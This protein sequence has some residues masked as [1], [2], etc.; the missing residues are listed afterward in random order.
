MSP[1]ENG[2][3]APEEIISNQIFLIRG[4]KVMLDKDLAQLYNIETDLQIGSYGGRGE[5]EG[6]IIFIILRKQAQ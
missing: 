2:N 5:V 1:S 4:K 6:D 3:N